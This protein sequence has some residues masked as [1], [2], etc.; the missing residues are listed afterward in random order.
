MGEIVDDNI[1]FKN[2]YKLEIINLDLLFIN[3]IS[4]MYV[5]NNKF[6]E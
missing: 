6:C 1:P 3:I 2:L 5:Y 4:C